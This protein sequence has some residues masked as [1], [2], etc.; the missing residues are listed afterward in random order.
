MNTSTKNIMR[1]VL[2]LFLLGSPH[3]LLAAGPYI[4]SVQQVKGGT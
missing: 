4:L 3:P 1:I 2:F